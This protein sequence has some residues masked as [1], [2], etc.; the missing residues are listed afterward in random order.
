MCAD[1]SAIPDD[2]VERKKVIQDAM[3]LFVPDIDVVD[4]AM[5]NWMTDEFS[6]GG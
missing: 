5:H 2:A 1:G 3:R 4:N 6:K